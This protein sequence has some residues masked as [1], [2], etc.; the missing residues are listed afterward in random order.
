MKVP[1]PECNRN[2]DVMEGLASMT[3][4]CGA[5]GH[6]FRRTAKPV[7]AEGPDPGR[8]HQGFFLMVAAW[9]WLAALYTTSIGI[10]LWM[11]LLQPSP[12]LGRLMIVCLYAALAGGFTY[13]AGKVLCLRAYQ[14]VPHHVEAKRLRQNLLLL[15]S[16]LLIKLPA[17]VLG[18][19]ILSQVG[20]AFGMLAF[21]SFYSFLGACALRNRHLKAMQQVRVI[22]KWLIRYCGFMILCKLI[23]LLLDVADDSTLKFAA[24]IT[25]SI[26]L[27]FWLYFALAHYRVLRLLRD[28]RTVKALSAEQGGT[29]NDSSMA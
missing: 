28:C 8:L 16:A 6:R 2:I 21:I 22:E 29:E 19:A 5:C 4:L 13:V 11:A 20:S 14:A 15:L 9:P 24:A 26:T 10:V 23:I 7:S 17:A 25:G 12:L 18:H 27:A 1:C 3:L